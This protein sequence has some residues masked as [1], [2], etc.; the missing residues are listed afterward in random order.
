MKPKGIAKWMLVSVMMLTV[1]CTHD[2]SQ[3]P[4]PTDYHFTIPRNFPTVLNIP[5]DNPLTVEGIQLGR[6]LFYDGRLSGRTHADSL[7]GCASCHQQ[8]HGFEGG[9]DNPRFVHGHPVGL[10]GQATTHVMLPLVNLIWNSNAYEWTGKVFPS[11]PDASNRNIEDIVW[12]TVVSGDELCGDTGRVASLFQHLP[13]YPQLFEKAFGSPVVTMKNI[14]RA[15]AQ[16]VRTLVSSDSRFDR[17][18]RG[19]L[20]LSASELNGYQIFMTEE[21]GD[22]FHCHG[23]AGNPLF[24]TNLFYNNGKDTVFGSW[25]D[26]Y[27]VSGNPVDIGAYKAPTLRN[28]A[29]TGPYM[30]DGRFATLREV[31]DFY[32]EGV[33]W[34][35]YIHSLMHHVSTGGV[36][37]TVPEKMDLIAFL[38]SL[39]DS[40]FMRN[41]AF[42]PP[43]ELPDGTPPLP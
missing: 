8:A 2:Q 38:N 15:I 30:H 6:F 25:P 10:C 18:L 3:A 26:H 22:C 13:G 21:G 43:A 11:N 20:Q 33:K 19:G 34:S 39:T 36:Q 7:M 31:V 5:T 29:L 23:G 35:P 42:G 41:P 4:K 40:A 27:S 1:S 24:T 14:S 9:P 32:S 28:C 12:H 37:L 17:Y 16:F